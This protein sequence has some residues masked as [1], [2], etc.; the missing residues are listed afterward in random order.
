MTKQHYVIHVG[1]LKNGTT[2]L[3]HC[4]AA[5]RDELLKS[6]VYYPS[7][8]IS[9]NNRI[10]HMPVYYAARKLEM[11]KEARIF[12]KVNDAGHKIVVLSCEHFVR[13][14]EASLICLRDAIGNATF[15]IVYYVR[16]W[17]DRLPSLWN[18]S[19][20]LGRYL[21]LPVY[22]MDLLH[23]GKPN[24]DFDYI[25]SWK[26]VENVF[27][28]DSLKLVPYSTLVDDKVDIFSAFCNDILGVRNIPQPPR[29][30]TSVYASLPFAEGEVVRA[31]ND[32]FFSQHE[33]FSPLPHGSFVRALR[34]SPPEIVALVEAIQQHPATLV[35]DDNDPTFT[36][37]F[38]E[39]NNFSGKLI[40]KYKAEEM[41]RRV[42]AEV[43]YAS[44]SYLL[45]RGMP[46]AVYDLYKE[47]KLNDPDAQAHFRRP[48]R[49]AHKSNNLQ[50]HTQEPTSA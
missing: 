11:Q 46:D 38:D 32:M 30:G 37:L 23:S 10:M 43:K 1:P 18:Q 27:G 39:M 3:Q 47:L 35:I 49:T 20:R 25:L 50:T 12:A 45:T 28:Q 48:G 6:G 31:L 2:Y 15:E 24:E 4:L 8:L 26:K 34:K 17:S 21:P 5:S 36:D 44:L 42:R 40:G 9:P 29:A 14:S 33:T 19:L 13:L 7:E 22:C 16:R 41:F